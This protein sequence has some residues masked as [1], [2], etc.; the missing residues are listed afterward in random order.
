MTNSSSRVPPSSADS[1]PVTKTHHPR[2]T[3]P[4][5]EPESSLPRLPDPTE[6]QEDPSVSNGPSMVDTGA[7]HVPSADFRIAHGLDVQDAKYFKR[8][9]RAQSV[10]PLA[11]AAV[12]GKSKVG[13][14]VYASALQ[15]ME[16]LALENSNNVVVF[17]DAKAIGFGNDVVAWSELDKDEKLARV[18]EYQTRPGAGSALVG[19]LA[20]TVSTGST[21][22]TISLFTSTT[23]LP[24]L[25]PALAAVPLNGAKL[26]VNVA[27]TKIDADNLAFADDFS[28]VVPHLASVPS[29]KFA[30]YFSSTPSTI[31]KTS[32]GLLAP[33]STVSAI[34][35]IE[36]TF[37]GRQVA[38]FIYPSIAETLPTASISVNGNVKTAKQLFVLVASH[39]ANI[40]V[41]TVS[42]V[43]IVTLNNWTP[44]TELAELLTSVNKSTNITILADSSVS[45]R[46]IKDVVLASVY[47]A[48]S[49]STRVPTLPVIKTAIIPSTTNT[50]SLAAFLAEQVPS[51]TANGH[52]SSTK[53][54]KTVSFYTSATHPVPELIAHMFLAS[55]S[56]STQLAQFGSSVA[57]G[58]KSV[59][60]LT[61]KDA[62]A[63]SKVKKDV[64]AEAYVP[65]SVNERS[66]VVWITEPQI[67]KQNDV[68]STLADNALLV[69]VVPWSEEEV[70]SK[71]T[72][73]ERQTIKDRN[74][75]VFLLP[76]SNN[77]I[78]EQVA[79]LMLYTSQRKL[80]RSVSRVLDAF[81]GGYVPRDL[82]EEAQAGLTEVEGISGWNTEAE[83]VEG[84]E[85]KT[86]AGW[87]W[88]ALAGERG[89]VD[90]NVDSAPLRGDWS[91]AARKFMFKEAFEYGTT[92]REDAAAARIAPDDP[93]AGVLALRPSLEEK[94]FVITVCENRR[95]T[96]ETY[97][98][99]VFHIGFDTAGTG[100]TYEV[101]E[102]LGVHGWNDEAEVREFMEWYGLDP[103]QLVSFPSPHDHGKTYE[104]R[105]AFQLLQQNLDLF[106]KPS[107][108]FYA[109]L[110]AL[111]THKNDQRTL[112]FIAAPEGVALFK[113]MSERETVTFA[114]VLK[115]F[116]SAR[117]SIEELVGMIPEIKPRH[118]SIASSQKAVGD[119]VELLIVTVDW[120][121]PSGSPRFG[122][123]TRY[124]ADLVVGAQVTVSI[125]PSVMKLPPLDTQPVIMAG[126]G[127]GA[128]PFRAFIQHRAWQRDQGIKVGPLIYY[129]G[130]RYRSQ[131]Y[132]YGEEIEAYMDAGIIT[133][134]GLAFSR[135]GKDKSYIQHKMKQDKALL[136]K[137]LLAK[138]PD[139]AY[140]Y[141]CGPTW[142]VPDVYEAL[143]SSLVE[144]GG[145]ERKEAEDYIEELKEEERYVLEVY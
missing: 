108:S 18:Q 63:S 73:A 105:T 119:K 78:V 77:P 15:I 6:G 96:P 71:L 111:A 139:A 51:A 13:Q 74:V 1:K 133:H 21:V 116:K 145:K 43:A 102:A 28:S 38:D 83:D 62:A 88:D 92:T 10:N 104:T 84:N 26:I 126:L 9:L 34:H 66:D 22:K 16:S 70:A 89:V 76:P 91:L 75:R 109:S 12:A 122:Q 41:K 80:S 128:A 117:P 29:D 5:T 31:V 95:L 54:K 39:T 93:T 61:Q 85:E 100:L 46:A 4:K 114:D 65:I 140:F 57:Q 127:T 67:L 47:A 58:V 60:T 59:L 69:L 131:E 123:C 144:N 23:T 27:T 3:D 50:E 45:V 137:L 120:T 7:H 141:L 53:E 99:N 11:A 82:A 118:Y 25:L 40:L 138:G 106:G 44:S 97:D 32:A 19:L 121:T 132:L 142:P 2:P 14:T 135:D 37:A 103:A 20:S 90:V 17:D 136:S 64:V 24:L 36:S 86:K 134:A 124:L 79:F 107:K 110:A 143:V 30:I 55:P 35:F 98:R 81:Y 113:K 112:R 49:T 72:R 8:V 129:F 101:G 125:K 33:S 87:E 42:D 68:I 48:S 52:Q 56:L 94:T 115:Q 130:S